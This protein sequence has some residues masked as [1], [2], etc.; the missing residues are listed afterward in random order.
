MV[1]R[2][3]LNFFY[4]FYTIGADFFA[5]EVTNTLSASAKMAGGKIFCE[6]YF[7]SLN[8]YFNRVG[9]FNT[10]LLTKFFRNNNAAKFVNVSDNAGRFHCATTFL[11]VF[12]CVLVSR[13]TT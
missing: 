11:C 2:V 12:L 8:I 3:I 13:N 9:I 6:N 5:L 4:I 7:V 1:L 10:Q